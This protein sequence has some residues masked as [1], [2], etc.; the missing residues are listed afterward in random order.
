MKRLAIFV[1][2]D[3]DSLVEDY[4]VHYLK[5]LR[6]VVRDIHFVSNCCLPQKE[7]DKVAPHVNQIT[8]RDNAG[9]DFAAWAH[10]IAMLELPRIAENYDELVLANS[11]CYAAFSSFQNI[12]TTML[13][14][15]YD[16]WGITENKAEKVYFQDGGEADSERHIQS[17]FLVFNNRILKSPVFA[18]FWDQLNG[19]WERDEVILNAEVG[20][21][22]LLNAEGFDCVPYLSCDENDLIAM[23]ESCGYTHLCDFSIGYWH[24]LLEKGS[25]LL[26]VKAIEEMLEG[27]AQTVAWL[28]ADCGRSDYDFSMI[29]KH[30]LRVSPDYHIAKSSYLR[31]FIFCLVAAVNPWSQKNPVCCIVRRKSK[32]LK[33]VVSREG[34]WPTLTC[35]WHK[36]R[37]RFFKK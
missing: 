13:E 30:L 8:I 35:L 18:E 29:N 6:S 11:S 15:S 9:L 21:T 2:F 25:P 17:Y 5:S 16:M 31:V 28:K 23:R 20:L 26:K 3:Q 22:K 7:Q 27:Y 36:A 4:V 10:V 1:H 37:S 14:R 34:F 24:Q 12:F 32:K 19:E 33:R